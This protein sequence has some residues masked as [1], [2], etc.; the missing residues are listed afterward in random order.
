MYWSYIV[1][2]WAGSLFGGVLTAIGMK[3]AVM[4]ALRKSESAFMSERREQPD[5]SILG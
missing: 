5:R 3:R 1:T 4:A 2:F